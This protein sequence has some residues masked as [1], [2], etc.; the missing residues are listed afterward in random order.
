MEK[1]SLY[2]LSLFIFRRDLRL[3]DN[4]ALIHACKSSYNII[5]T[6]FLD[7]RQ[8]DKNKNSYFSSNCVQFMLESLIDLDSKLKLKKS[9]LNI[10]Y[11]N[12]NQN[13]EFIFSQ[14]KDI[15][16]VYL[17]EDYTPFSIARDNEIKDICSK[18]K[19]AFHS[20]EDL[21]LTDAH[22]VMTHSGDFFKVYTPYCQE[23][24]KH[25]VRGVDSSLYEN[26][27]EKEK[28][29]FENSLIEYDIQSLLEVVKINYNKNIELEGGRNSGLE[30]VKNINN[31]KNYGVTRNLVKLPSTRFSAYLK[32]GCVSIREVYYAI[33]SSF[34]TN[35]ELI[36]QLH[37]RDFFMKI[38]YFFPQVI[39]QSFKPECD[40]IIWQ[41]KDED[42]EAWK[43]GKT[44]FPIVDAAMRCLNSTGY[45]HNKLR[46]MV[47]S[48]LV[49]DVL[50]DWRIGE[51]YFAQQLVDYD[52]SLNNGGWQWTGST[53]TDPRGEPRIYNPVLQ[54]EKLDPNC[55]FIIKWLPELKGVKSNH[56]HEW[57]KYHHLYNIDYSKPIFSHYEQRD[58]A[59]KMFNDC[60][61]YKYKNTENNNLNY[62][63]KSQTVG[64]NTKNYRKEYSNFKNLNRN[65]K[66]NFSQ[67]NNNYASQTFE[68]TQKN[69]IYLEKEK[70]TKNNYINK[71]NNNNVLNLIYG[72]R[73]NPNSNK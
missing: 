40:H 57:E 38:C 48:F 7:E 8:I 36:K 44:G 32:F 61:Y 18:Y 2:K 29:S 53:G 54:S 13:L 17:N 65:E 49:K 35:H 72:N 25:K 56:I 14:N 60:K 50:A 70:I 34:G 10:F 62:I 9:C 20:Y 58:K 68:Y 59:M 39:G 6:F 27:I 71:S 21:M 52:I 26:F 45:I 73:N 43:N 5:P 19:I 37:W 3:F 67:Q 66:K 4:T 46:T 28:I 11:G 69:S 1:K 24:M 22:Q 12:L 51:K 31:F 41:A 63:T 33:Q 42:I 55:E 16:A 47:C 23:A 15:Q 30:I 64:I